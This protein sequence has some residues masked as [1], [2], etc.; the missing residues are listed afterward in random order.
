MCDMA[1]LEVELG[2]SLQLTTQ[3]APFSQGLEAQSL[4]LIPQF[5]PVNPGAHQHV[6]SAKPSL[7]EEDKKYSNCMVTHGNMCTWLSH[8]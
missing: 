6:Y 4:M 2:C 8:P 3:V 7:G 1:C 5:W